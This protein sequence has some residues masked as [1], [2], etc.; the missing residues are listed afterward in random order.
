M[1]RKGKE[2][3]SLSGNLREIRYNIHQREIFIRPL[4]FISEP[5][6]VI[7]AGRHSLV[8]H[9]ARIYVKHDIELSAMGNRL[10]MKTLSSFGTKI[11]TE[12]RN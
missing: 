2:I 11:F 10:K 7:A 3:R 4:K 5:E 9:D 1:K 6:N 8:Y 12:K